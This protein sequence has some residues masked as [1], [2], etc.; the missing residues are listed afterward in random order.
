MPT[1]LERLSAWRNQSPHAAT[2]DTAKAAPPPSPLAPVDLTDYN[3][4][5]G[6]MDLAARIGDI[7]LSSG[8][9]NSDTKAQMHAVTS[10]YGLWWCHVDITM[11]NIT[12]STQIGTTR[13]SPVTVF[14]V[15]RTLTTDFSKLSAVD[16]LIRSIQ[17]GATPPDVAERILDEIE[18][19]PTAYGPVTSIFGWGLMGGAVSMLLGGTMLVG[20]ISFVASI[21]IMCMSLLLAKH[22][23][24]VFFQ[25][26]IGGV[27][28]T[29]PAALSYAAAAEYG[30]EL[31]PSQIVASG[32]IVMLAGLTLVQSLQ[33]G[34]TGAP[35]TASAHFFET[36]L[37]TGA[38]VAGV[39]IG[40]QLSSYAGIALPPMESV[41]SPNPASPGTRVLAGT[42]ASVGFAIACYAEWSAVA[43]SGIT[44][45][46]GSVFYYFIFSP[47]GMSTVM[48]GSTAAVIIGFAGGLL[49]RRF[50][51]PPLII[52]IAGITPL[53]PGLAVYRGMYAALN[54]Q[55]LVGFTNIATALA[56][57][58]GLA[59][60]VVL[61]E[62]I[63]RRVRRPQ[64]FN[65]YRGFRVAGRATL[66]QAQQARQQLRRRAPRRRQ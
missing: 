46:T 19:Q 42:L 40:L 41:A 44:A 43:I 33:D 39:A 28:A 27:I 29:I 8:T 64:R 16:R 58:C 47:L 66:Q 9:S 3:Q 13:K 48:A 4:V 34:I 24:P 53:L 22:H 65:P 60:G 6:V 31:R 1:F 63:A 61:G 18:A 37:Y 11:N 57:S 52:A 21:L 51:V 26:V 25:N 14:R 59:A 17:A 56:I 30:V 20:A 2:I 38:I 54:E 7:L 32:I 23:L 35:V 49:A 55:M 62:W 15:V 36:L 10:A 5:A 45:M 50:Q 12:V